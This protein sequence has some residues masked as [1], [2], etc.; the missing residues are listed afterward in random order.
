MSLYLSSSYAFL[1]FT[2]LRYQASASCIS[3]ENQHTL[4]L[5]LRLRSASSISDAHRQTFPRVLHKS[6][7]SSTRRTTRERLYINALGAC[8]SSPQGLAVF[9]RTGL[10]V[11][12][13]P[14]RGLAV[15]GKGKPPNQLCG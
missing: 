2:R 6:D 14:F 1:L 3:M 4:M 12:P 8:R 15:S 9:Y 7:P 5:F 10:A 13:C 11:L